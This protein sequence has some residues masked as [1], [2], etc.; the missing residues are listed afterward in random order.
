MGINK[1]LAKR[2]PAGKIA[3]AVYSQYQDEKIG[4]QN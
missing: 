2:G 1:W 3:R 4:F